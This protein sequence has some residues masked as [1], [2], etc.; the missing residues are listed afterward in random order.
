MRRSLYIKDDDYRL[1]FLYGNYTTLTRFTE[2][3]L[4]RVVDERLSPLF[5][6]IHTTNPEMRA[7]MLRN[8]RGATSLRWLAALLDAGVEVHGQ[9]VL[10]PGVN[11]GV[12]LRETLEDV[13]STYASLASL[14]I[15]PVGVSVFSTEA[16][17]RPAT[18]DEARETI[19]VVSEYQE[20][21]RRHLGRTLVY[22]SD[23]LYLLAGV[24]P[25]SAEHF[26]S[27]DQAENGI[28]LT[29][30]FIDSFQEMSEMPQLGSGFFQSV[31]GAPAWGYRGIRATRMGAQEG[32]GRVAILTGAYAAPVLRDLLDRNGF[33][34]VG[35]IPV[36]NTYFGGNIAVAGL[37]TGADLIATLEN[38]D[39]N[40]TY[41]LPDLCLSDDLFLDGR[42]LE[43]LP[44]HVRVVPTTGVDLRRTLEELAPKELP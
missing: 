8:P 23:E 41:L 15:V 22:A 12:Y 35:V 20:W 1:S 34:H 16:T 42:K 2:F 27:L 33:A 4:E 18:P 19:S 28:G 10:C 21:A 9:V 32:S 31:D 5:V 11:D 38:S 17:M 36:S 37:L 29:A 24:M 44:R 13:M 7:S 3:D 39:I 25:P 43:E 30:A 6:S 40:A 14:S 26:D